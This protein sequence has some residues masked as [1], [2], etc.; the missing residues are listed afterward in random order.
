[1]KAKFV[2]GAIFLATLAAH[3]GPAQAAD[4]PSKPIHIVVGST[5]GTPTDITSRML[6][7]K[8][9]ARLGQPVIIDNR[10]G[11]NEYLAVNSVLQGEAD[12]HTMVYVTSGVTALPLLRKDFPVDWRKDATAVSM[13]VSAPI[14]WVAHPSAPFNNIDQMVAYMKA[15]PG[16]AN[17]GVASAITLLP[18]AYF[19]RLTGTSFELV[20]YPGGGQAYN[21]LMANEITFSSILAIQAKQLIESGKL[22]AVG[23]LGT[24][25]S[26]LL[27]NAPAFSESTIPGVR[28]IAAFSGFNSFWM[29]MLVPP[30]T[31]RAAVTTLN[32]A[33]VEAVKDPA[34]SAK[35]KAMGMDAQGNTPEEFTAMMV[36]E[37][38]TWRNV[39]QLADI[40]P[41]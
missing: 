6:M 24:S 29:G 33:L 28:E 4:F 32:A 37:I 1:M 21:A 40:K 12:G 30:K 26:P 19:K 38:E 3:V 2:S 11:A 16:K 25:R 23:M 18:T 31:P 41:E 20:R 7:D 36:K 39:A 14:A 9:T 5:P 17:M 10:P 15:N 35:L 22:K 13:L 8:L 27:P 34:I